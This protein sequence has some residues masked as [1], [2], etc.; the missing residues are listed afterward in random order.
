[1]RLGRNLATSFFLASSIALL[2]QLALL[3]Y[4]AYLSYNWLGRT[5]ALGVALSLWR[6]NYLKAVFQAS[7]CQHYLL[8][9][10]FLGQPARSQPQLTGSSTCVALA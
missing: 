10:T 5:P 9:S 2:C 3:S 6:N 4:L 1:M 7:T 8:N